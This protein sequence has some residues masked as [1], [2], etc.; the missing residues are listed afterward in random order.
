MNMKKSIYF[1]VLIVLI[2]GCLINAIAI[3]DFHCKIPTCQDFHYGLLDKS[4]HRHYVEVCY[5]TVYALQEIS[6]IHG[7]CIHG[8]TGK[9]NPPCIYA[10]ALTIKNCL[11]G[12]SDLPEN[13][14]KFYCGYTLMKY[15]AVQVGLG[16]IP[17]RTDNNI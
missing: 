11:S 2:D 9:I 8:N 10:L 15:C 16:H 6:R 3:D 1:L 13:T 12:L 5:E 4:R 14:A 7:K 17:L